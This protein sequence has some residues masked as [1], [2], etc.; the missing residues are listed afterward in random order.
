M[1][2]VEAQVLKALDTKISCHSDGQAPPLLFHGL[3]GSNLQ[4]ADS[5][6]WYNPQEVVQAVGYLNIF[7]SSGLSPDDVGIITPY[8]L[9]VFCLVHMMVDKI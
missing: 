6:S 5:H 3:R 9:Q 1:N 4:E 7:Y 2:S 8:Q